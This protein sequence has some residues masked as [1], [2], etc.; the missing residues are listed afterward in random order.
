MKTNFLL[1][2]EAAGSECLSCPAWASWASDTSFVQRAQ[3]KSP[4]ALAR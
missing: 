2:V 3:L 1:N 4:V